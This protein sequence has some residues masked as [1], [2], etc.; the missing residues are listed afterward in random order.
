MPFGVLFS[1][2]AQNH[3]DTSVAFLLTYIRGIAWSLMSVFVCTRAYL[4]LF[5]GTS[6]GTARTGSIAAS[7]RSIHHPT[8]S[9]LHRDSPLHH[10]GTRPA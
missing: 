6:A 10:S 5:T 7:R 1:D 9:A 3:V 4:S 8:G 2:V